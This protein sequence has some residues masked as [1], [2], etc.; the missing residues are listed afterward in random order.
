METRLST[1]AKLSDSRADAYIAKHGSQSW[2]V[3]AL[4]PDVLNDLIDGAIIT[5]V[6][7]NKMRAIRAL[8]EKDKK[9]VL[10]WGKLV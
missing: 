10:E 2:E 9:K 8:E 4:P 6:D 5:L 1:P 7:R 3:D